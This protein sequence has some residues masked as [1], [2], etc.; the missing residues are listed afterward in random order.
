MRDFRVLAERTELKRFL[1]VRVPEGCLQ[2]EEIRRRL[3]ALRETALSCPILSKYTYPHSMRDFLRLGGENRAEEVPCGS[4]VGGK[5]TYAEART[6][7][8]ETALSCPILSKDAY[9][10]FM[11]DFF[12][13]LAERT[14]MKGFLVARVS[15]ESR[16][17]PRLTRLRGKRRYPVRYHRK[18]LTRILCGIFCILAERTELKGFLAVRVSA[19]SRHTP[20]VSRFAG[21]GVILSVFKRKHFM[22]ISAPHFMRDFLRFDGEDRAEGVPCGS[23]A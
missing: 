9:P 18:T 8:W 15:A 13:V 11:R 6:L 7:A 10:H 3:P 1:V 12:W 16:H 21:N 23:R 2:P 14:A 20:R 5:P 4:R 22:N 17:T 19:E